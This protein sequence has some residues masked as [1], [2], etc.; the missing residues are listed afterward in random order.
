MCLLAVCLEFLADEI[1]Q[2]PIPCG[3]RFFLRVGQS[4]RND[5]LSLG[6]GLF[7]TTIYIMECCFMSALKTTWLLSEDKI[8]SNLTAAAAKTGAIIVVCWQT[9]LPNAVNLTRLW[10]NGILEIASKRPETWTRRCIFLLLFIYVWSMAKHFLVS[11]R[12]ASVVCRFANKNL[13]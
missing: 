1:C 8:M 11:R 6:T 9:F 4:M 3:L 5:R 13:R 10:L 2:K 12:F 7:S